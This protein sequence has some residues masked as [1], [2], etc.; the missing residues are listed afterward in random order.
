M[1]V[2]TMKQSI[3]RNKFKERKLSKNARKAM[4]SEMYIPT[5]AVEMTYD[6]MECVDGGASIEKGWFGIPIGIRLTKNECSDGAFA[7]SLASAGVVISGGMVTIILAATG[8]GA[9]G[10]GI[11]A[12]ISAILAGALAYYAGVLEKGANNNGAILYF[13]PLTFKI[14]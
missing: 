1:G 2:L 9:L 10:A 7:C 11:A 14:L 5:N 4:A 8:V 13:I 3:F 6:E 12:G